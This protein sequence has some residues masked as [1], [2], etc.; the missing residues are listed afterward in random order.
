MNFSLTASE[1]PWVAI[2]LAVGLAWCLPAF[3]VLAGRNLSR[4]ITASLLSLLPIGFLVSGALPREAGEGTSTLS[5]GLGA[6]VALVV[7]SL[8]LVLI[9]LFG[10]ML[11]DVDHDHLSPTDRG[12]RLA[13]SLAVL[14]LGGGLTLLGSGLSDFFAVPGLP[15]LKEGMPSR[16]GPGL[17]GVQDFAILAGLTLA[18]ALLASL[19]LLR[20]GGEER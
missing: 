6:G 20:D 2:W 8:A 1:P 5:V 15:A 16:V 11:T 18:A 13:R 4:S 12:T 19:M 14:I 3:S 9:Q 7:V 10:W 17:S